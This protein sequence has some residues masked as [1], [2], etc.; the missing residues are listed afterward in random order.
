M[1]TLN[2]EWT[3]ADEDYFNLSE[4]LTIST[5]HVYFY[6]ISLGMNG[7]TRTAILIPSDISQNVSKV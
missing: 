2:E 1:D 4:I 3:V 6:S 7:L 5:Q